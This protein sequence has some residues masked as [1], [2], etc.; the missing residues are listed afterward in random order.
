MV[1]A[2]WSAANKPTSARNLAN[3]IWIGTVDHQTATEQHFRTRLAAENH[4]SHLITDSRATAHR[5]LIGFDFAFGYPTGFAERLTGQPSAKA[6]WHWLAQRVTD[7]PTNTNN[8]F[9]LAN[10][11]NTTMG[12][13]GPFWSHPAQRRYSALHPTKAGIDHPTLGFAEY[14]DVERLA[15]TA[16]SVFM[17]NNPGAVAS[18]SLMGLPMIHRLCQLPDVAVWPFDPPDGPTLLAEVYPALLSTAVTAHLA[19]SGGVKDQV[20]VRLLARS[21]WN[22]CQTGQ[23]AAL[24]KN[25]SGPQEEGWILGAGHRDL[26][27]AALI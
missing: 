5:L 10:Q 1:I 20:Q 6:V 11:I 16:K 24:L 25:T 12:G 8:R 18:Q 17:L 22:L 26:L 19:K 2:D 23:I 27:S 13:N 15:K 3:A 7:T 9:E 14:R 4:L 21:L